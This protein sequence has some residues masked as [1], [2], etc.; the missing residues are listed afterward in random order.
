MD[1]EERLKSALLALRAAQG[2]LQDIRRGTTDISQ[3]EAIDNLC[4]KI[5]EVI[6]GD[7]P[8][9]DKVMGHGS[10]LNTAQRCRHSTKSN[11]PYQFQPLGVPTTGR[12]L[13]DRPRSPECL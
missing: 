5:A 10:H 6:H 2:M 9:S 7:E 8:E 11:H 4:A 3:A 13:P 1:P 12:S